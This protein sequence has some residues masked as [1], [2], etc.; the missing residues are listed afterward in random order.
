MRIPPGAVELAVLKWEEKSYRKE[1]L[2]R[3]VELM[4]DLVFGSA[5]QYL[6]SGV[7]VP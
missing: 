3:A 5:I 7:V 4:A 2:M 1:T 6:R